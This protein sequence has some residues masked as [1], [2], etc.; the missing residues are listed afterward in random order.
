MSLQ[1]TESSETGSGKREFLFVP[2]SVFEVANVQWKDHPTWE[3]P[4]VVFLNAMSD[5]SRYPEDL[6]LSLS[7]QA[8][9]KILICNLYSFAE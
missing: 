2:Y 8:R 4:H 5:N 9:F 3:L 1:K 6:S 7:Q